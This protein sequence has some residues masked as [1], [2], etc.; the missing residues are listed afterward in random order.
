[1]KFQ[2][3]LAEIKNDLSQYF[4]S[5][6]IDDASILKWVT[7]ALKKFGSNIMI[8]HE[9]VIEINKG[10]GKLP[11]NFYALNKAL[12]CDKDFISCTPEN[13]SI[14]VNSFFWTD[15]QLKQKE[16]DL[17]TEDCVE[18][19]VQEHTIREKTYINGCAF[20]KYYK[21]PTELKLSKS[22]K[23]SLCDH[24]CLN[25][26]RSSSP[27]EINII[28]NTIHTNFSDGD[29]YI[30]F[31]GLDLDEDGIVI[32]PDTPKGELE[33]YLTYFVKRNIFEIVMTNG[34]DT[35]ISNLFKYYLDAERTQLGLA[36]T[37][38]KFS[39]LTPSSLYKLKKR[40]VQERMKFERI[41]RR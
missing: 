26:F 22:F 28:G 6:L 4:E 36:L 21:N 11:D 33:S 15:V 35:N 1:M 12:K 16:W 38:A 32:I 14:L 2:E 30:K 34:D 27:Y 3:F 39:T 20:D 5:G 7:H 29:V 23:K 10:K 13:K 19:R 31:K 9:A 37:E 40:N 8:Y 24:G 17:C 18:E 25:K 41:P